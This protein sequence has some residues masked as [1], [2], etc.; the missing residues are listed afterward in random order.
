ML[1]RFSSAPVATGAAIR[2]DAAP[3]PLELRLWTPPL[4][5]LVEADEPP[6]CSV[7]ASLTAAACVRHPGLC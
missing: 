6:L 4:K 1:R 3:P 5:K 7:W 2:I